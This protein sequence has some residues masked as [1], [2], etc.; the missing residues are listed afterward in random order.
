MLPRD[1]KEFEAE[2]VCWLVCERMGIKNPSAEYLNG[3]L[4]NSEEIPDISIET[5]L[6]AVNMVETMIK[7]KSSIRKEIVV[8]TAKVDSND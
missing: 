7:G 4:G 2:S 6:K 3:Y 8:E 1:V 5:V